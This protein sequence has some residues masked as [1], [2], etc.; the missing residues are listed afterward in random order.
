MGYSSYAAE[1]LGSPFLLADEVIFTIPKGGGLQLS[2]HYFKLLFILEASLEHEIMGMT[3]R[4]PLETGDILVAPVVAEHSYFNPNPIKAMP[5][6]AMRIFLDADA[7]KRRSTAKSRNPETDICDFIL[8]HFYCVAQIRNGIDTEITEL[9]HAFRRETETRSPGFLLRTRSICSDLVVLVARKL[10]AAND[11]GLSKH[12][13]T[14][15]QIVAGAK[16]YIFK[17]FAGDL[18]LGEIAWHIGKGEEHLARVFK[19]ETGQSVFSY[20]REMRINHAKT[21]LL[22]PALTLTDIAT[23]CGFHSLHF[24]S[25]TFHKHEGVSPSQ[26]RRQT[27]TAASPDTGPKE[28]A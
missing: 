5:L 16:E 8:R 13:A 19:K 6:H 26:Y 10:E 24:F 3:G 27:A 1:G 14:H 28:K 18:T 17:H 22:N 20:V 21:L 9:I 2:R 11:P 7:L 23:R 25:R 12:R 15:E 4:R